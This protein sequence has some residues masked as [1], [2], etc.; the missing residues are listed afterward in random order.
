MDRL[1]CLWPP[2]KWPVELPGGS[3]PPQEPMMG[4]D[5]HQA[6]GVLSTRL[7]LAMRSKV[8]IFCAPP[9]GGGDSD[10]RGIVTANEL[11]RANEPIRGKTQ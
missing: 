2:S 7:H 10:P 8:G 11:V 5:I 3:R 1:V 4:W 9:G 6:R